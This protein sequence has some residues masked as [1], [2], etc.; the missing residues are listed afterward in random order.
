ME[1]RGLN[2]TKKNK[3]LNLLLIVWLASI[4]LPILIACKYAV[5]SVDDFIRNYDD[6]SLLAYMCQNVKIA[7]LTWQGTY[8][9]YFIGAVPLLSM[10]GVAG[11]RYYLFFAAIIF[12]AAFILFARLESE[13]FG[14]DAGRKNTASLAM[15]A[16]M[17]LLLLNGN[18]ENE[19]F[20]WYAGSVTYVMET[21]LSF[22]CVSCYIAYERKAANWLLVVGSLSAICAV[23]GNLCI[24]ALLCAMLL[25]F[26]GYDFLIKKTLSKNIILGIVALAGS[27]INV[28]APGNYVRSDTMGEAGLHPIETINRVV[29]HVLT[30]L[31]DDIQNGPM[32]LLLIVVF[33]LAHAICKESKLEFRYPGLVTLYAFFGIFITAFPLFLGYDA[34]IEYYWFPRFTYV[35]RIGIA[36][37]LPFTV[38]YWGGYCA[39]KGFFSLKKEHYLLVGIMLII[40]LS[41]VDILE[42]G[43]YKMASHL[44][45]GD[46]EAFAESEMSMITQI[47]QSG[48]GD[49]VVYYTA[50]EDG[51]WANLKNVGLDCYADVTSNNNVRMAKF[52]GVNSI[53][54]LPAESEVTTE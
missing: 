11:I 37:F 10:F 45:A 19:T 51:I 46:Y 40:G 22:V 32:I 49:V 15:V 36:I 6:I 48:G 23:G 39:K 12:F 41:T 47:E 20:Y 26:I 2:L 18:C 24:S 38:A 54:V 44:A 9:S 5:P 52:Y 31:Y 28:A 42:W 16:I 35:E 17:L 43:P 4:V 29:S 33:L 34:D 21:V 30:T 8:F 1:K 25:F 50:P 14:F 13:W 7:Y 27:L 53:Y 3:A